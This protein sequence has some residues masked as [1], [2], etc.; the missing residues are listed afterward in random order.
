MPASPELLDAVCHYTHASL[1]LEDA[2]RR[3]KAAEDALAEAIELARDSAAHVHAA[4][5]LV[6]DAMM[7]VAR[8]RDGE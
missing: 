4:C 8:L 3:A 2:L 7:V 6:R 5:D 1:L